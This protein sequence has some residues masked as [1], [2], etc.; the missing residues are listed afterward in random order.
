MNLRLYIS[1]LVITPVFGVCSALNIT[2]S[3]Y[4]EISPASSTGLASVYVVENAADAVLSYDAASS[5]SASG[6]KWFRFNAMG[7]G[8]AE[9]IT[10]VTAEGNI[11]SVHAEN[12][13]MGYIVEDGGRQTA[14]WIVDYAHHIPTLT[15]FAVTADSDCDRVVF[16]PEG[17]F[18]RIVFYSVNGAPTELDR[19]IT[20]SY[21]DLEMQPDASDDD[22][23]WQQYTHSVNFTSLTGTFSTIAPLC[24]TSFRLVGDRFLEA[25]GTPVDVETAAYHTSRVDAR[26][27]AIQAQRDND[28]ESGSVDSG[29]GGSAPCDI[30]FRAVPTDA[31]VFREWQFSATEDFID[32]LYRFNVDDMTYTFTEFGTTY[33]K[34]VCADATGDCMYEGD[35]YTVT[36]GESKLQCPNA[37]SPQ[38]EDGV[39]DEWKV[40]YSS[41]ISYEC[42]IFNRWGK[43]LFSSTNPAE[44]W[45]GRAGGKFV[46]SGVYFYVIKAEGA[47]GK[48]YS[49]KGDINIVGSKLKT[50]TSTE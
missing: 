12:S 47:D 23:T 19:Q 39:N 38:N 21:N 27:W 36:I 31:A 10:Q 26:T 11:S 15:S 44:G 2:G 3:R 50:Q 43:E 7:G 37:F 48:K 20:L 40:S 33:V 14:Y 46:P 6:V 29:L 9:Q 16:A 25:W 41:L 1:A 35:V 4:V 49:L 42:H 13:D 24:D 22:G 32:V 28:N 30:T 34:Y 18:D 45:D 17:A 8:Y 5:Q